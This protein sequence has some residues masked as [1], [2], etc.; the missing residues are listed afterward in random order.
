[1]PSYGTLTS[2]H[3]VEI[4]LVDHIKLWIDSYLAAREEATGRDYETI[5]RPVS[6]FMKQ[7]F[8]SLPGED[9]TPAVII[10]SN[11]FSD[12]PQRRGDGTWD[13][14]LRMA[15]CGLT[16]GPEA[17]F[18]RALAGDYQAALLSLCLQQRK[19]T[20]NIK[21]WS[22]E[23]LGI[24][25]VDQDQTRTLCAAR[26]EFVYQ[27]QGFSIEVDGPTDVLS[28]PTPLPADHEVETVIITPGV[29]P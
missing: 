10:V 2:F 8:T 28:P 15:V 26:L 1:M 4:A 9:R 21:W 29:L 7:T 18:A 22:W 24:D 23:D 19:I 14:R 17:S 5:A 25:D 11:G 13:V 20:D 3:D 16:H 27:V 12:D 6:Y